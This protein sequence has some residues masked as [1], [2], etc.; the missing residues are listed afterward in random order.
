MDL[1][2]LTTGL[3]GIAAAACIVYLVRKD[4]LHV[5]YGMAWIVIAAIFALLGL[6][7]GV[8]DR[9][10]QIA[11]VAY[12]PMLAITLGFVVLVL[13]IL[14]SDIERSR[15]Q[16]RIQRLVQRTALLEAE[17]RALRKVLGDAPPTEP[18]EDT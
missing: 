14:L 6:F 10:G 5:R 9:V 18:R 15:N 16:V 13:K 4:R 1:L 7:P 12:P 8:F 11:G 17:I 2:N 3:I